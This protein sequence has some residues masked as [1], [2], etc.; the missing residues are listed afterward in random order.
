MSDSLKTKPF[1]TKGSLKKGGHQRKT[2]RAWTL[3]AEGEK[4]TW[5]SSLE[6]VQLIRAGI[7]YSSI[8]LISKKLSLPVKA[9]LDLLGLAQT[10][11]NKKKLEHSLLDRRN[12]ELI[13][14]ISE[15]ADFGLEVFNNEQ[16]KFQS[17]LHKTNLSLGG[18]KPVEFLDTVSGINEVQYCLNRIEYGNYA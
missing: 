10:T 15:V 1:N 18:G 8:E 11:Y 4:Y 3:S 5:S 12:S 13:L 9:T 14:K 16:D 7:P 6:R 2:K 17:W